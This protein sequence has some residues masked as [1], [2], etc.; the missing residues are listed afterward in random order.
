MRP[1]EYGDRGQN[2]EFPYL[3]RQTVVDLMTFPEGLRY[4]QLETITRLGQISGNPDLVAQAPGSMREGLRRAYQI[5]A[6]RGS[7]WNSHKTTVCGLAID[8]QKLIV[9]TGQSDFF[10]LRG[11][12][13]A[14]PELHQRALFELASARQTDIPLGASM[15]F[16]LVTRDGVAMAVRS[17]SQD[18][19]QGRLSITGEE[20]AE[21]GNDFF[22]DTQRGLKEE[23]GLH[24]LLEKMRLLRVGLE[25]P[26]A[27]TYWVFVAYQDIDRQT[28]AQNWASAADFSENT[29]LLVVPLEALTSWPR[30]GIQA[31][32]WK[33]FLVAGALTTTQRQNSILVP[34]HTVF[35]RRECLRLFQQSGGLNSLMGD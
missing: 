31:E 23:F 19:E 27:Y 7:G 29:S 25:K 33:P 5:I 24:V 17:Q 18:F 16:V 12:D 2:Q 6:E 15:H 14:A 10:T 13:T 4:Y 30:N 21:P 20:Q 32:W 26:Y 3:E 8:G 1:S 11:M 9:T 22:G 34:H 35:S 28:L